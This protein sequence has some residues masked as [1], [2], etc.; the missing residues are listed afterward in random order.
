MRKKLLTLLLA[1]IIG[2]N[3]AHS[4]VLIDGWYVNLNSSDLTASITYKDITQ[5]S[6]YIYKYT[7][8]YEGN[9]VVPSRFIYN[10]KEYIVTEI[11]G[12]AFDNCSELTSIELPYTITTIS[13]SAFSNCTK[14]TTISLP[15]SVITIG[16][17]AFKN[18]TNLKNITFPDSLR[19][20]EGSNA[21]AD[22]PNIENVY[23]GEGLEY[24][25]ESAFYLSNLSDPQNQSAKVHI[26]SLDQWLKIKFESR[27]S[28][29]LRAGGTLIC[30]GEPLSNMNITGE[31][32][33]IHAYSFYGSSLQRVYIKCKD[34]Y[35]GEYA[36][37]LNR[38][39]Q[40]VEIEGTVQSITDYA[41]VSCS[42][43]NR[44][45]FRDKVENTGNIVFYDCHQLWHIIFSKG[46]GEMHGKLCEYNWSPSDS[47]DVLIN[48][49]YP[50][51]ISEDKY[52]SYFGV[53]QPKYYDNQIDGY[54]ISGENRD[55][56]LMYFGNDKDI[57][58][59]SSVRYVGHHICS[60]VDTIY[61]ITI[62]EKVTLIEQTAFSNLPML[63]RVLYDAKNASLQGIFTY[64]DQYDLQFQVFDNT[65]DSFIIT[66]N[67]KV[68][69]S[70]LCYGLSNVQLINIPCSVDSIGAYAFYG[71]NVSR[72]CGKTI[73]NNEELKLCEE[74][75]TSIIPQWVRDTIIVQKG[76]VGWS[77]YKG[78]YVQYAYTELY[79][80][81][82]NTIVVKTGHKDFVQLPDTILCHR[83][84]EICDSK[85]H[86]QVFESSGV[87]TCTYENI[88]GCDSIVF[89][90]VIV[91]QDTTYL[92]DTLIC[93]GESIFDG[94]E[95]QPFYESGVYNYTY[96]NSEGCDSVI[97][98]NIYVVQHV[99]TPTINVKSAFDT[100]NSG[101]ITIS[102]NTS[103][104]PASFAYF[105]VNGIKHNCSSDNIGNGYS[106]NN[107]AEGTYRMVFYSILDCDSMVKNITIDQ[108]GLR[109]NGMYY[110]LDDLY[111]TA[112]LT[113]R[114]TSYGDYS[115]EYSGNITIP[116]TITFEGKDYQVTGIKSYAFEGCNNIK[117]ITME[118]ET[119]ISMYNSGLSSNCI[120]YV[121][122]GSLNAYK[123]A[124][125]WRNYTIHVINPSHVTTTTGT[126]SATIILGNTNEA[127]HIASCGMEGG[128]EKFAG[129]MIEYIGLE[130]NSEY[131]NVL[132]FIKTKE[133]DLD[134]TT[135]SFTTTALELTTK[136]SK[137]VSS[138]T[139]IL[140]A[141]TNMSDAEVSCGFEW[142][143][144]DAP[145]DMAGTKVFCP[146][147]SGQMAGRL[148]NLKDDVY[149]KY[150]AFYQSGAGNMY[151]GDWQYI[152]TGDNAV[153]FDP[154]LYTYGAT[155][156][157]ENEATISGYAL[158]GSEDFTEQGFEYWAESRVN[159]QEDN[160]QGT[161]VA[162][163]RMPAALNEHFFVQAS[164][165]ALRAILT[166]LDAGTVYKYRVYGKA[167]DQYYYGSEQT[168][169]TQGEYKGDDTEAIEDVQI[170]NTQSTKAQKILHNGQIYILRGEKVYTVT[171]QEV[172]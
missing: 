68:I 3:V 47:R 116:K 115:G 29:P 131:A 70:Y 85:G 54:I 83:G 103:G 121:P 139:A 128:E 106:V 110:L 140:L 125:G 111:H 96:I 105:T 129:N 132:L 75:D 61:S 147:A 2:I 91:K 40:H 90:N 53:F 80:S 81:I 88:Y 158:A 28:N 14:L 57:V 92:P 52:S 76:E 36:F 79:D 136:P 43:L 22:C 104:T 98:R 165:I 46:I 27:L 66:E 169:T 86:C 141:E 24:I 63:K 145:A 119:P 30:N 94:K 10:E 143:R 56:L 6:R 41:F 161:K 12:H 45:I 7:S 50:L 67:V 5:V 101:S 124:S 112:T 102:K 49:K 126:T 38:Q 120:I 32:D 114:G 25:G 55:T 113:Y 11:G 16:S 93:M 82:I 142:K 8:P 168:F 107:L 130:P 155:V 33:S 77:D 148:K 34:L 166:N 108:Y 150:R 157:R 44:V 154:I 163:R 15:E 95:P 156:V 58:I 26:K 65:L 152:F 100:P 144:N 74:L 133:G 117:S 19:K 138:N 172:R 127:Q 122:Y 23:I 31:L 151:Y 170:D 159:V 137:A 20:I 87:L 37:A 4:S 149:Y 135:V 18:C 153:E 17:E 21:F 35:I 162:P 118:S 99:V 64:D 62:P 89:R 97:S 167:G 73:Y 109:I 1:F 164:G 42:N 9:L 51:S 48:Q 146:V 171:G 59:P 134:N 71:C 13:Y 123:S 60:P 78:L 160:V 72:N 39:L 84:A 69:P